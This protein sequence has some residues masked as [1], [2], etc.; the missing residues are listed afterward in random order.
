MTYDLRSENRAEDLARRGQN[1]YNASLAMSCGRTQVFPLFKNAVQVSDGVVEIP[2]PG[3]LLRSCQ[4]GQGEDGAHLDR[5]VVGPENRLVEVAVSSLL[6]DR[7]HGYPRIVFSG[8]SGTGKSHLA[9][10]LTAAWK[11]C[12]PRRSAACV[13]ALDFAR[14]LA[15]AMQT[16]TVDDFAVRY[17]GLSLLVLEDL[18][19]LIGKQAAQQQLAFTLDT[20]EITGGRWIV[21]ANRLAS[22][23]SGLIAGLRSRL[24]QAL[25]VPLVRPGHKARLA[26]IRRLT[27]ARGLC[28][29][30]DAIE[31]LATELTKTVP[32]LLGAI[33]DLQFAL[34][35][36]SLAIDRKQVL[37]Y[38]GQR[39]T[40]QHPSLRQIASLTAQC[41]SLRLNEMRGPSRRQPA[42]TA[43]ALAM[44]LARNLTP[45]TLQ[46]IGR[47]FG[48]RD[49]TTVSYSCR[50]TEERIQSEP[51]IEDAAFTIQHEL[52]ET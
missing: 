10:G 40:P 16:K 48:G 19:H 46:Q 6:G 27:K 49:H 22:E 37:E 4:P 7:D 47:Y 21:T 39:H 50:K 51:E 30:D 31:T 3:R 35:S 14:E 38:L 23:L 28:F 1:R 42:P 11:S 43:R 2:L 8:P 5:F 41:F 34:G 45:L 36:G 15:D 44:Y 29:S 9:F 24:A 33:T 26:I 25:A 52:Q 18:Q 20:L 17:R 12:F 32:E 13:P